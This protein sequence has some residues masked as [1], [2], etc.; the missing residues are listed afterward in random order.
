MIGGSVAMLAAIGLAVLRAPLAFALHAVSVAGIGVA[1]NR[2]VALQ[3]LSPSLSDA[4]LFG[5]LML[6]K[7]LTLSGLA[8]G[9]LGQVPPIP[10]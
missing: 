7:L 5:A 10:A 9:V 6:S 3:P 4:V 8:A 1:I 2:T